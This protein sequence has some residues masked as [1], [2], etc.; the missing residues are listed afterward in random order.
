MVLRNCVLFFA[1]KFL[2]SF[3][4]ISVL[5]V[6]TLSAS[7][8]CISTKYFDIIYLEK[9]T[10]SAVE[11]S[12]HADSI[13]E[14]I[15]ADYDIP[16]DSKYLRFPVVFTSAN[17]VFNAYFS[18]MMFNHIVLY[19]TKP[20]EDFS[21]MENTLIDCF[22]HELTHALTFNMKNKFYRFLSTVFGDVIN[23][24]MIVSTPTIIS[25]GAAISQE[26]KH[27]AG[28]MNDGYFFNLIRGAK[29]TDEFPGFADV[30]GAR[31]VYPGGSASYAFGGPFT[32]YLIDKYGNEKYSRFWWYMINGRSCNGSFK[33]AFGCSINHEWKEFRRS[34]EVPEI[35]FELSNDVSMLNRNLSRMGG[36]TCY[37]RGGAF[38]DEATN[39]V[40]L[41]NLDEKNELTSRKFFTKKNLQKIQFSID[42][43]Y[44][45]CSYYNMNS[46]GLKNMVAVYDVETKC[47]YD[48][49]K[50]HVSEACVI[51]KD[52]KTYLV[53]KKSSKRDTSIVC[54]ELNSKKK[55]D[56]V[57]E[58]PVALDAEIYS[59]CP[60][61]EGEIYFS[62]K[63]GKNWSVCKSKNLL[64]DNFEIIK[65]DLPENYKVRN[66]SKSFASGKKDTVVF[67]FVKG[68]DLPK[69]GEIDFDSE[70][71]E[72]KFIDNNF[73]GGIFSPVE[74]EGII[75]YSA[76]FYDENRI[77]EINLKNENLKFKTISCARKE[78]NF[79]ELQKSIETESEKKLEGLPEY[80]SKAYTKIF[81]PRIS[82]IPLGFVSPY[83]IDK[84][85]DFE[86][87]NNCLLG[88]TFFMNSIND[89]AFF[90]TSAGYD[91]TNHVAGISGYMKFPFVSNTNFM[92]FVDKPTLIFD[93][94]G[95]RQFT[96]AAE[97]S[98][99]I[100][101]GRYSSFTLS[102]FNIFLT[103]KEYSFG[104]KHKAYFGNPDENVIYT[105]NDVSLMYSNVHKVGGGYY[106]NLGFSIGLAYQTILRQNIISFS[107]RLYKS[108]YPMGSLVLPYLIPI[109]CRKYFTYNLPVT[110]TLSLIPSDNIFYD[111]NAK[112]KLFGYDIQKGLSFFPLYFNRVALEFEYD[113]QYEKNNRNFEIRYLFSDLFTTDTKNYEDFIALNFILTSTPNIEALANVKFNLNFQTRYY[114]HGDDGGEFKFNFVFSLAM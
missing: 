91:I 10:K 90:M 28:R 65:V 15:C 75:F 69:V 32:K 17:D 44:I 70:K 26:S 5:S 46:F 42:G 29:I 52:G 41:Y 101:F 55:F 76:H 67:S 83:S 24:G 81:P 33:K 20:A 99:S 82:W 62:F 63:S 48:L 61:D 68:T 92:S 25:E 103:G 22:T 18:T 2:L 56:F 73:N 35:D 113:G 27:G 74:Y 11:L 1:M 54:Y 98:M 93:E 96:N 102:D 49:M 108:V 87:Y 47:I 3:F 57:K 19:D 23:F 45:A 77:Y 94:D 114:I 51:Y 7:P 21:S 109:E 72:L 112:M 34:Y 43:K 36:L 31:D 107:G 84:N 14:E 12:R 13:Y 4:V 58:I 9:N 95:F 53:A 79:S 85:G 86:T 78:I 8:R 110:C 37:G 50:F 30:M 97:F 39:R 59:F 105:K 71:S 111:L 38:F 40:Y 88:A 60:A 6:F 89:S 104:N 64:E 100:N 16:I 80:E 106:E 66:F